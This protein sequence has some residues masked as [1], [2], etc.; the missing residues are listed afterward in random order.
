MLARKNGSMGGKIPLGF[1]SFVKELA[2]L[3]ASPHE[4][5]WSNRVQSEHRYN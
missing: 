3:D 2:I 4:G 1:K 5:N